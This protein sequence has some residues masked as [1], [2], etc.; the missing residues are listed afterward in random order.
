MQQFMK[1]VFQKV[2]YYK[3]SNPL[4]TAWQPAH[5]IVQCDLFICLD[6]YN[7]DF[8]KFCTGE[9]IRWGKGRQ[10]Q[11]HYLPFFEELVKVR[12][13]ESQAAFRRALED[14]RE[15]ANGDEPPKKKPHVR[16]C[17]MSDAAIAGEVIHVCTHFGGNTLNTKMLFGCRV[18]RCGC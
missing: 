14:I 4:H 9:H 17:K 8:F 3:I 15:A 12:N 2:E 10:P 7:T 11:C 16:Q 6:K 13:L 5:Q 1:P 18:G